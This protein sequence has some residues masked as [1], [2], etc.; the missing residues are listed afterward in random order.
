MKGGSL[1]PPRLQGRAILWAMFASGLAMLVIGL[2]N[3]A[4][5]DHMG[6][7]LIMA[8]LGASAVLVF[9]IYK[10]PFAQPR[11][12][13]GGHTLSALA[14]VTVYQLM[15]GGNEIVAVAIAVPLAVGLMHSTGMMHPPGG[16]TAFLGAAGGEAFHAMGY[17]FVLTPCLAG[18]ATIILLALILNNIPPRQKYPTYW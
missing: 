13:V 5:H 4:V 11:N 14:G 1:P 10:S 3:H 6:A 17:W 2:A 9:G 15:G 16:A 12:V 8:P 7:P 18:S